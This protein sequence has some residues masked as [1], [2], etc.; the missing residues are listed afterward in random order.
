[1]ELR[2]LLNHR[3]HNNIKENFKNMEGYSMQPGMN[4][5]WHSKQYSCGWMNKSRAGKIPNQCSCD[6]IVGA[7]FEFVLSTTKAASSSK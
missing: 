5:F 7:G 2:T 1:V 4:Y 6:K 3:C